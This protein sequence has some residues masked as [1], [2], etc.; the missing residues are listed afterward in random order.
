M[1]WDWNYTSDIDF[2][3]DKDGK[4]KAKNYYN[5]EHKHENSYGDDHSFEYT[6]EGIG[7]W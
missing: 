4:W 3:I 5:L 6:Y 2:S 1:H 7:K